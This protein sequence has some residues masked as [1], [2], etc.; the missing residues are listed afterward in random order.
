MPASYAAATA[1]VK[2]LAAEASADGGCRLE[3]VAGPGPGAASGQAEAA[4]GASTGR[5]PISTIRS[6][7]SSASVLAPPAKAT[8]SRAWR[9][10]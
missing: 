7:P 1:S 3:S 10:Q 4:I 6:T 5:G 9:R 2:L 8:G